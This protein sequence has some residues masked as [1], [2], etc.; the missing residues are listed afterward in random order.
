MSTSSVMMS[1]EEGIDTPE[2]EETIS[3]HTCINTNILHK[4]VDQEWQHET[5]VVFIFY[6]YL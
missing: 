5:N 2:A 1:I 6:L 4:D 3:K